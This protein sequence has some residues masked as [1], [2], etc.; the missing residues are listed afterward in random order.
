MTPNLLRVHDIPLY[1]NLREALQTR[2]LGDD[3]VAKSKEGGCQRTH[4]GVCY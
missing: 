3:F 2:M 4:E 1:S